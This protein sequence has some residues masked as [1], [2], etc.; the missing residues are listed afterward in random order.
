MEMPNTDELQY[1]MYKSMRG[2]LVGLKDGLDES[3]EREFNKISDK[4]MSLSKST[5]IHIVFNV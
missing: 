3:F 2:A 4:G 1:L 5:T